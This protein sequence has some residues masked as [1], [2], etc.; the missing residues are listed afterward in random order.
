MGADFLTAASQLM[1]PH[2]GMV[3]AISGNEQVTAG[4]G[5][6]VRASDT[7]LV[8][9]CPFVV[10]GAL[11]P[12]AQVQWLVAAAE[13]KAGG[14]ATLTEA[15]AGLCTAADQAPQGPP[16]VVQTQAQGSGT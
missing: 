4:G 7:F 9:G 14:D 5:L 2:G 16:N 1:C 10:A 11:H 3:T 12:C 8:A 15:S 6:L 13:S